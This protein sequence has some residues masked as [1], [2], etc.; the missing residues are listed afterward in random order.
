MHSYWLAG[1]HFQNN[2]LIHCLGSVASVRNPFRSCIIPTKTIHYKV[3]DNKVC[4]NVS[5]SP[6]N[7]G[8]RG[9]FRL[10]M[11]SLYVLLPLLLLE[12]LK[13]SCLGL[14]LLLL[15]SNLI[16]KTFTH[17]KDSLEPKCV[18]NW[19]VSLL[20]WKARYIGPSRALQRSNNWCIIWGRWWCR[21]KPS[22]ADV[23]SFF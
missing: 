16:I 2:I 5:G 3:W 22:S 15:Q 1:K 6:C 11:L 7:L 12:F 19:D 20:R 18:G 8:Q 9:A 23:C 17:W 10:K 13:V 21:S 14:V 4:V